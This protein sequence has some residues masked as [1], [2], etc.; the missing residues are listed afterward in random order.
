MGNLNSLGN[1]LVV[2]ARYSGESFRTRIIAE[3]FETVKDLKRLITEA[4]P[5]LKGKRIEVWL[6][7]GRS[8][9]QLGEETSVLELMEDA[10]KEHCGVVPELKLEV[11]LSAASSRK[12]A[13]LPDA[14]HLQPSGGITPTPIDKHKVTTLHLVDCDDCNM[15]PIVGKRY[16]CIDCPTKVD[17]CFRCHADHNSSHTT[18]L[19]NHTMDG[20][21]NNQ[22]FDDA[23]RGHEKDVKEFDQLQVRH[24]SVPIMIAEVYKRG[25]GSD[26][27]MSYCRDNTADTKYA[28][29]CHSCGECDTTARRFKSDVRDD[30][31]LCEL[32]YLVH[33]PKILGVAYKCSRLIVPGFWN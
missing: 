16:I 8:F 32:C 19:Y 21:W 31:V 22:R 2:R 15:F 9:D 23:D 26:T 4:W 5:H 11:K 17:L 20:V 33:E 24:R 14:P 7:D 25:E 12:T 18:V 30:I 13:K 3:R 6:P 10:P 28:L 27:E 29:R 1:V